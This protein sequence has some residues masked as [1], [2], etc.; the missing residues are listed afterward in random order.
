MYISL[1]IVYKYTDIY[2]DADVYRCVHDVYTIIHKIKIN[3]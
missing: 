2:I 1:Q 3:L